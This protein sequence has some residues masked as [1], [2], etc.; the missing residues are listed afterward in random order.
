VT[1]AKVVITDHWLLI[2]QRPAL[3]DQVR[4][5]LLLLREPIR[6]PAFIAG[7]GIGSGGARGRAST[8]PRESR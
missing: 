2:P 8:A 4:E 7:A 1:R 5:F 6:R 3:R